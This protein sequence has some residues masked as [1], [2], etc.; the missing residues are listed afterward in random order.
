MATIGV[1]SSTSTASSRGIPDFGDSLER[2]RNLDGK[3]GEEWYVDVKTAEFTATPRLWAKFAE[4]K[5]GY[6]VQSFDFDCKSVRIAVTS[7]A[8]YGKDDNLLSSAD[9]G[10]GWQRVIPSSMGEQMYNG[11][12]GTR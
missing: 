8:T 11:M 12:C 4:K 5:G 1:V 2:W 9:A 3:T 7:T 10:G 6:T